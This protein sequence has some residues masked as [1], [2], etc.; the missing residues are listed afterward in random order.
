MNSV[1]VLLVGMDMHKRIRPTPLDRQE[2]WRLW[3]TGNW[4]VSVL[5]THYRVSRPTIYKVL[6]RARKQEFVPRKSVNQRFKALKFG[7]KRL[8]KVEQVL[9]EKRRQEALR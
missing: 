6:A 4:K 5:A 1:V 2:I 7:L 8:A 3:Q 9:E